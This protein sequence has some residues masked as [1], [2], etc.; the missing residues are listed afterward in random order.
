M[1]ESAPGA[2]VVEVPLRV[3]SSEDALVHGI[4]ESVRRELSISAAASR[5]L[6][7]ALGR[8]TSV[9]VL[10][11]GIERSAPR[12]PS[13]SALITVWKDTL[14]ALSGL[15]ILCVCVDDA[16]LLQRGE[17]G[18]L[19]TMIE[20]PSRVPVLMVVAGGP[21]LMDKLSQ[22][23][24]SPILRAFSGA[25]FDLGQFNLEETREALEVPLHLLKSPGRWEGS[26]VLTLQH[27]TRGYPYLVQCFAAAAY[28][29][30]EKL[31]EA[32]V[33]EST[34]AAL[35]LAS[36][37]LER[38]LSDLSDEDIRA[39][40]KIASLAKAQVRSS[41]VVQLGVNHIYLSRLTDAGVLKRLSRGLYEL[42]RAP[43][44]AYYHALRRGIEL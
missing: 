42:R 3:P 29:E 13:A 1:K 14:A 20:T 31:T 33:R 8:L 16:E 2:V 28:R 35:K 6:R 43:A 32:I 27:L 21:E 15:P 38:E 10:G 9:S 24:A 30:G 4:A 19:K 41:E 44:I 12:A 36:S 18:I 5:R 34:P 37:W 22:H 26:G 17:V 7:D 11:T 39:F 25:I 23:D 40:A